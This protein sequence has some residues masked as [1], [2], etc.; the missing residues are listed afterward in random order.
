M[1]RGP[2]KS[3][4]GQESCDADEWGVEAIL[5]RFGLKLTH[6]EQ[7]CAHEEGANEVDSP[8]QLR[9]RFGQYVIENV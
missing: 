2:A 6:I 8:N 7:I 4:L 9:C 3:I 1:N 5:M